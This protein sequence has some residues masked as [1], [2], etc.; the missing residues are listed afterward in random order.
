M[1]K[2]LRRIA[3]LLDVD[4]TDVD[5]LMELYLGLRALQLVGEA[6]VLGTP[7]RRRSRSLSSR[8]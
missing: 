8:E 7:P 1:Q 3:T 6:K 2:R 4:L 5:D